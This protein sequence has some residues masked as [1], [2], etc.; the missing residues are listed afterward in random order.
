MI[1]FAEARDLM[2]AALKP[3]GREQVALERAAGRYLAADVR[4]PHPS[5]RFDQS[6]M[7]GY[8]VRAADLADA[9]AAGAAD[10][11]LA[12]EIPAGTTRVPALRAG[13][14]VKVFTGGRLPRGADAVVMVEHA[15]LAEGRVRCP[16]AVAAGAHIRRAGE[17]FRRGEIVLRAGQRVTPA[18]VGLLASFGRAQVAVA[19]R[20]RVVLIT[21]GDELVAPGE[22]LQPGRI[23]DANGPALAAA[24]AAAGA[25][26]VRR[27]RVKDSRAALRRELAAAIEGAD[28]V[29][30]VGG[31]SVGDHD[32]VA[33]ARAD[34][35][36][37]ERF[38]RVAMQPG[39]P[40]HFGLA[41][42][43]TP[44]F[45]LPG[46]PVSALVAFRLF[47]APALRRLQGAR[48]L[49]AALPVR[50]AASVRATGDRAL[51]LRGRLELRDDG[52]WAV[53]LA[54]QESYMLTGLSDADILIEVP[55]GGAGLPVGASVSAHLLLP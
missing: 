27:R 23:H 37:R 55:A 32:H 8:A 16:G 13:C 9:A 49:P 50:L 33:G 2:L 6:V 44:V 17:E 21:M 12:G 51:F 28:L 4:A 42:D 52:P 38:H 40:N 31:A 7:D 30:T 47:V 15:T 26:S 14:A 39:K 53:P 34:L 10:L 1:P 20:P 54:R 45:G 3:L 48:D 19:R 43:G 41:P 22:P 29:V 11:H 5:P 24:L 18:V 35:G 25:A 46:N 36:L